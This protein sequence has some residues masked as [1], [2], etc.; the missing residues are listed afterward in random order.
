MVIKYE[1]HSGKQ[2]KIIPNIK[3]STNFNAKNKLKYN[4]MPKNNSK[5]DP[6]IVA[7]NKSKLRTNSILVI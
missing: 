5:M 2:S 4:S 7:G 6:G 3:N 1:D